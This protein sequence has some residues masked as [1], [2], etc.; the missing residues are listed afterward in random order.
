MACV[1]P[2][3]SSFLPSNNT[4]WTIR[5]KNSVRV[6]HICKFHTA[7]KGN[8]CAYGDFCP[9]IHYE[10]CHRPNIAEKNVQRTL[11]QQLVDTLGQM[12]LV[13]D[14]ILTA[15]TSK[16]F[17]TERAQ[18]TNDELKRDTDAECDD[19]A[20]EMAKSAATQ[21]DTI[22]DKAKADIKVLREPLNVEAKPKTSIDSTPTTVSVPPSAIKTADA[23]T[24]TAKKVEDGPVHKES[25]ANTEHSVTK[26]HISAN[27]EIDIKLDEE[28]PDNAPQFKAQWQYLLGNHPDLLFQRYPET[29]DEYWQ[30]FTVGDNDAEL[31]NLKFEAL[32]GQ[33]VVV[34]DYFKDKDRFH[35]ELFNY[36]V[37][38][39]VRSI[40]RKNVMEIQPIPASKAY[41][42]FKGNVAESTWDELTRG[43]TSFDNGAIIH[44][45]IAQQFPLYDSKKKAY[46]FVDFKKLNAGYQQLHSDT[47]REVTDKGL[48]VTES[49]CPKILSLLYSLS[50]IRKLHV[51]RTFSISETWQM[52]KWN[53]ELYVPLPVSAVT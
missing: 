21:K 44:C 17:S 18:R 51:V 41:E 38:P 23:L 1:D 10:E 46:I 16:C 7:Q 14:A 53:D 36:A 29:R 43:G 50:F 52:Q 12:N 47:I 35:V 19:D 20:V 15:L 32:N 26:L 13:L 30:R 3:A 22:D 49:D 9:F 25:D 48:A 8:L 6:F 5:N 4:R 45:F 31:I 11:Q 34:K 37:K 39:K 33:P 24:D 2:F 42:R 40:L 27:K 28:L